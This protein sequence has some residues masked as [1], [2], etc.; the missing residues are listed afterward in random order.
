MFG[1]RLI[2][3]G[4]VSGGLPNIYGAYAYYQLNENTNDSSGNGYNG[5]ETS[6]TY[7]TS[8]QTDFETAASFN[9]SSSAINT[10]LTP[11]VANLRSVSLWFKCG[12]QS[13]F[14]TLFSVSSYGSSLN[15]SW[16]VCGLLSDGTIYA[17]YG[18]A[19]GGTSCII[20]STAS[21][22]D[23]NWH[24]LI[25]T[26][27]GI[28]GVGSDVKLYMD[29]VEITTTPDR[30]NEGS[31][32]TIQGTFRLGHIRLQSPVSNVNIL[33]GLID[34]VRV[35]DFEIDSTIRTALYNE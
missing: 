21:Y 28:Y 9:G 29:N 14:G 24:N 18:A 12:S 1:K 2:N 13:S 32:A 17:G 33:D 5:T 25:I 6:I 31:V 11:T 23:N 22:D 7:V 4:G 8:K 16:A 15:Y 34:Q 27:N 3:T 35:Y 19:N 30:L 10:T 26:F 20:T